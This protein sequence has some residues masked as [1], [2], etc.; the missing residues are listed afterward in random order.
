MGKCTK[1][2]NLSNSAKSAEKIKETCNISLKRPVPTRWNSLYD[3]LERL[4]SV[5]EFLGKLC[6]EL[7]VPRFQS[8]EIQF[9]KEFMEVS[10]PVA[11]ALDKL[12]GEFGVFMGSLLPTLFRVKTMITEI[13]EK[14]EYC[15]GFA[16]AYLDGI[17][18]RFGH[19]MKIDETHPSNY[20]FAALTHPAFKLRWVQ[21]ELHDEL[22]KQ[23]ILKANSFLS[24]SSSCGNDSSQDEPFDPFY[25]FG[26]STQSKNGEATLASSVELECVR[27]FNDNSKLL[28][29]L[30]KYPV[31]ERMFRRFNT[32]LPSSA[33]V[34]RLFS[35]AGMVFSAKR[36]NLTD[37]N[38]EKL[39]LLKC[40]NIFKQM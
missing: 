26:T 3:S 6:D 20:V 5:E 40:N 38:F 11:L 25:D 18:K 9:L 4:L 36:T 28:P 10:K 15:K 14:T 16:S 1:L 22:K 7:N 29:M 23:F 19:L 35:Y 2:F 33:P 32:P 13:K 39:V 24:T 30:A 8:K 34:E 21:N 37:D 17:D 31:I 12:Q 27:Y